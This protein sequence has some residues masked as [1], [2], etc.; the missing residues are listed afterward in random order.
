MNRG[1]THVDG[2]E[3]RKYLQSLSD[4]KPSPCPEYIAAPEASPRKQGEILLFDVIARRGI[5]A[6][7]Q[8]SSPNQGEKPRSFS[9]S[10]LF[11]LLVICTLTATVDPH[12]YRK[13]WDQEE[14]AKSIR[15]ID[16]IGE[17]RR[18]DEIEI[19]IGM[20][21]AFLADLKEQVDRQGATESK[22]LEQTRRKNVRKPTAVLANDSGDQVGLRLS[23]MS[24]TPIRTKE[25]LQP[26]A[27]NNHAIKLGVH[28]GRFV[29]TRRNS[30]GVYE[31]IRRGP[32]TLGPLNGPHD[33]HRSIMELVP[34]IRDSST[35]GLLADYVVLL[36]SVGPLTEAGP[37]H[38]QGGFSQLR[39]D[40][41]TIK[42]HL[43]EHRGWVPKAPP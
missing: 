20:V 14:V 41:A 12:G 38:K 35:L 37:E 17:Q 15:A 33:G 18:H 21:R 7:A 26:H 4:P 28:N 1:A 29:L 16:V 10:F 5:R 43:Y 22:V 3:I 40:V 2:E 32:A 6:T 19:S 31:R 34:H 42:T 39:D 36:E 25:L 23:E 11:P 9:T 30:A 8:A 13:D 24:H 27:N